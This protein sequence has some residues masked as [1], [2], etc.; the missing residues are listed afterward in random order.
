MPPLRVFTKPGRKLALAHRFRPL[1]RPDVPTDPIQNAINAA[2]DKLGGVPWYP[3]SKQPPSGL[4]WATDGQ[5]VWL[6]YVDGP[7]PPEAHLVRAWTDYVVIPK[8]PAELPR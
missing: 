8:P 4:V 5:L 1:R 7:L 2:S 3:R 6:I